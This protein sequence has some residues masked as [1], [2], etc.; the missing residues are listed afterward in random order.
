MKNAKERIAQ[1]HTVNLRRPYKS[2][3]E[4]ERLISPACFL[5]VVKTFVLV[6]F[7][8]NTQCFFVLHV[9]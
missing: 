3:A 4:K 9:A 2:N 5:S 7:S 8:I 1:V 6:F